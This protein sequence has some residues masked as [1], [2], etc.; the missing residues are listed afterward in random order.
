MSANKAPFET[1]DIHFGAIVGLIGALLMVL[2][3]TV[4]ITQVFDRMLRH[5]VS[6]SD[7][8]RS[9]MASTN[10]LPPEPRLQVNPAEDLIRLQDVE[11]VT[12]ITTHGS[13][14]RRKGAHPH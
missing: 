7:V 6:R 8:P 12:L 10:S 4:L 14:P 13:T 1:K 5:G 2:C 11:N 9:P 3:G